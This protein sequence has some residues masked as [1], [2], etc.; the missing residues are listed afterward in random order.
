L[1]V[2]L[3]WNY[4]CPSPFNIHIVTFDYFTPKIFFNEKKREKNIKWVLTNFHKPIHFSSCKNRIL[5]SLFIQLQ[6][7]F[8]TQVVNHHFRAFH[9]VK[10]CIQCG[11][12]NHPQKEIYKPKLIW[13]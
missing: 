13:N 2:S 1:E 7:L 6:Y 10:L 12:D 8:S 9:S 4:P 5:S 11:S 3:V